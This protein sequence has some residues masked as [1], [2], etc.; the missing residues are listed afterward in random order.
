MGWVHY[1]HSLDLGGKALSAPPSPAEFCTLA[2]PWP[3]AGA[4]PAHLPFKTECLLPPTPDASSPLPS[5]S[6]RLG[7]TW[8]VHPKDEPL[9][10]GQ[11]REVWKAAAP[12]SRG[13]SSSNLQGGVLSGLKG[14]QQ[15]WEKNRRACHPGGSHSL[16]GSNHASFQSILA[17]APSPLGGL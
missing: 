17:I 16:L 12:R 5:L 8:L 15:H 3:G 4:L 6:L 13:R 1:G 11:V 9:G 2:S 7:K 14:A 10:R